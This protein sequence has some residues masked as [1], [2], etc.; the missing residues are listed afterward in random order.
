MSKISENTVLAFE[1]IASMRSVGDG[2]V[3]LLANSGQL[4]TCNETS[5][6]MLR[7]MGE[8]R[9]ISEMT[10]A[11]CDEFDITTEAAS[12]DVIEIAEQLLEEG[13]LRIVE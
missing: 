10:A 4:Y 1:P 3:I 5:E 2:A 12:E 13:I 11:L 8:Q 9:S 6:A 7:D